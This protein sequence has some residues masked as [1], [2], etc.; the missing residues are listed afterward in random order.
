MKPYIVL[1]ISIVLSASSFGQPRSHIDH[2]NLVEGLPQRSIM[3]IMQDK[4]GFLWLATWNGLCKFDG[5]NFTNYK[6]S[7]NDPIIMGSNRILSMEEDAYGYIWVSSYNREIFRFDPRTEKYIATFHANGKPFIATKVLPMPSGKVWLTSEAMG[8][9]CVSDSLGT[10]DLFSVEEKNLPDN[11][12][13][14]VFEDSSKFSWLLTGNGLVKVAPSVGQKTT[15]EVLFTRKEGSNKETQFFSAI[16]TDS[17]IWF[18]AGNGEIRCYNKNDKTFSLFET[19]VDSDIISI[20]KVYENLFIILTSKDGFFICDRNRANLRKFDKS[21][22]KEL[23]TNEMISCFVDSNNNVW[24]ETNSNGVAKFNLMDN[25][26]RYY[27]PNDYDNNTILFPSFFIIEDKMG[28]I[29]VH[30]HGGFTFYDKKQDKLLPFFNNPHSPEWRFSDLLHHTFLDKQGNL[31]LSTRSGGLEKVVFDNTLFKLNDFYSNKI[32]ITGFEVRSV[33]EDA[34]NNIWLGNMSGILSIYDSKRNF[35]GFLCRDG[36]ISKSEKFLRAMSYTLVQDSKGNIWVGT[37][38]DGVYLLK[39]KDNTL[40]SFYIEQYK[41]N[42]NDPFSLSNDAIYSIHEDS[43]GRI[44]LGSYGGGINMFDQASKKFINKNNYYKNYPAGMGDQ[45]RTL[46][47]HNERIYIGTTL[48]LIVLLVDKSGYNIS[49]CKTYSKSYKAEDGIRANDIHDICVTKNKEVYV[50]TFGGG[51]SKVI[52]WDDEGFPSKFKTYDTRNGLYSDIVLSITEDNKNSLWINS[53]GSLSRFNPKDESFEQFNDISRTMSNQYFMETLPL[54]TSD[55]ELIYGCTHGTLSFFPDKIVQN[56]YSPYL[57]LTKFKV[58]NSDYPLKTQI[59]DVSGITL[60]HN[61]NIFSIEFIALDYINPH[62]VSYAYKLEGFDKDWIKNQ[63][64]RI[65]NYTNIPPGEYIFKVRSTNSNGT[66]VDNER[67]LPITI[68]PSFWQTKWAYFLYIVSCIILL[69]IILRSLFVFYRMKD[70]VLLEHEQTEMKT[71][72]FTDISHE[73]RTP[74]TMIVSPIENILE[75]RNTHPEIKPQLQLILKNANRMLNMV[76]QILDFRKIQKQKLEIKEVAVGE[77]VENLCNNSFKIAEAQNIQIRI[78]NQ[79]G[80][81]KIWVDPDG[82]EKLVFNLVSNSV[83]H[84]AKGGEIEISIFCKDKAIAIQVK[85]EG[86]GMTKEVLNKL[87]TRFASYSKDKSKPSTGIGLSM[88]KEIADKHHAKISVDSE[89]G[90]GSCFTILFLQ[91]LEHFSKDQNVEI[92]ETD[93]INNEQSTDTQY[94]ANSDTIAEKAGNKDRLS[95]LVV[96][97]DYELRGFIKSVLTEHYEVYE[98]KDGEEGYNKAVKHMPDFILSDIMM[99]VMDGIEFLHKIRANQNTSHIPFILLTAKTNIDDQLGGITSGA[100]DYII[101]PFS[102]KLL[103]A[104]IDNIIKQRKI[105]ADYIGGEYSAKSQGQS[106]DLT[107]QNILTERDDQFIRNLRE[108]IYSN[109][110]NSDFTIDSLVSNTNLSRRVFFNKVKSLTGQA[111]VEFVREIRI[112]HAAQLLKTQQYRVKEVT[113]MI[114]F[115]DIRYFTQCFKDMFGMTPSQYK[116]QFKEN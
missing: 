59:D 25:K 64:R 45:I 92:I 10:Q 82:I 72:F 61:E 17:E 19:G 74:L 98:A 78:N 108:D 56:I 44:W 47:S 87:F 16:E 51:M 115:S 99:P 86:E 30:P 85:D 38:G 40:T 43:Q 8:A 106:E 57:A 26:L 14:V 77:F 24:L 80:E 37:K 60:S 113:Y 95:I 73:I 105:Y 100:N 114:G 75:N 62:G 107:K 46:Q 83:K 18:G 6:T 109:L 20:K 68:T 27:T 1:I 23:P 96:E 31:W 94:T 55:G 90:K 33:L 70:K 54:L 12:V 4:K 5:Y 9:I 88:V 50:A 66:W 21:N 36:S 42:P 67:S 58:S 79:V 102:V 91:G 11:N 52:S 2:Y 81:K 89:Q 93:T 63:N 41:H 76:N 112:K 101:K 104:K 22:L 13:K 53:E 32:S 103:V 116:D 111:P 3:N 84:S 48:G 39:P 65:A 7:V 15:N 34:N 35:K 110:D 29:W 28:N 69:Y 49:G 97:D 71:R